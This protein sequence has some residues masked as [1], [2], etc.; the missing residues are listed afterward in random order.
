LKFC[1][2]MCRHSIIQDGQKNSFF[3]NG[4]TSPFQVYST[5]FEVMPMLML[6]GSEMALKINKKENN[7]I[8]GLPVCLILHLSSPSIVPP[9]I[10]TGTVV[11][12]IIIIII[13]IGIPIGNG[14]GNNDTACSRRRRRSRSDYDI[15]TSKK[16]NNN[17]DD[18]D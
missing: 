6:M 5:N 16:N 10:T 15:I 8:F 13:I 18:D 3:D 17:D 9:I 4:I 14:N 12:I 1:R 7:S 11:I 2:F